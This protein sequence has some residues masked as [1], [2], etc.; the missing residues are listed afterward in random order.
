[1]TRHL[2]APRTCLS[3]THAEAGVDARG[4]TD[5]GHSVDGGV[6]SH[7]AGGG[8]TEAGIGGVGDDCSMCRRSSPASVFAIGGARSWALV[9]WV[10]AEGH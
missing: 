6:T 5:A 10:G 9:R 8:A 3:G 7:D 1:M 4:G 2:P